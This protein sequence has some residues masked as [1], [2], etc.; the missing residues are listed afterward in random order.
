MTSR[1]TG[2]GQF[3]VI[4]LDTE[5]KKIHIRDLGCNARKVNCSCVHSAYILK[6]VLSERNL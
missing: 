2:T 4:R 5:S 3:K 1:K 6:P